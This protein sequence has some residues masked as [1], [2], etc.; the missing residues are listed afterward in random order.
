MYLKKDAKLNP[1]FSSGDKNIAAVLGEREWDM[2]PQATEKVEDIV[3]QLRQ[4]DSKSLKG[5]ESKY[6]NVELGASFAIF[7]TDKKL[8]ADQKARPESF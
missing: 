2:S 1:K 5:S 4:N 7:F 3:V 8:D 6:K